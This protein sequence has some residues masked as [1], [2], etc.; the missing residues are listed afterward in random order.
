MAALTP[1]NTETA[2]DELTTMSSI[3]TRYDLPGPHATVILDVPNPGT[4]GDD[5]GVRWNSTQADLSRLG[6]SQA[7]VQ[8]M[9]ELVR[10]THRRGRPLLMTGNDTSAAFCWLSFEIE[11]SMS[12]GT[13][14]ALIPAIH[15]ARLVPSPVIGAVIDRVGADLYWAG[16]HEIMLLTQIDGEDEQVHKAASG[17]W[18]QAR[19]QRH[20]EVIWDR[21]A[22]LFVDINDS[23]EQFGAGAVALTGDERAVQL[24]E[25]R[26]DDQGAGAV[27]RCMAGGRHE[28]GT[29][30]RLR[31]AIDDYRSERNRRETS[32][33]LESLREELGQRDQGLAGSI[34]VLEAIK[35][36]RVKTLFVDLV[37]GRRT[38]HVET[39]VRA[40]IGQGADVVIGTDFEVR[41][42]IAAILR[43]AYP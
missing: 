8:Q 10:S 41:D 7:T 11:A 20:S 33:A 34:E 22:S 32:T 29:P 37:T 13:L 1:Q 28:P 24:V 23:I 21:N 9:D 30:E 27:V 43:A 12:W 38:P 39:S 17:G 42:G 19:S 6:V 36:K 31:T 5:L 2:F 3:R 14:P 40:A 16:A 15:Q 4:V 25:A 35:D 18:S 26:L